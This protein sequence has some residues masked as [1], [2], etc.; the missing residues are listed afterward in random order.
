MYKQSHFHFVGING[1][2]MSGIAKILHKQ[3]HIVS[4]CDLACDTANI[5]EL[6]NSNCKISN[7]HSSNLCNNPSI[8]TVVYSSDVPYNNKELV[9]ARNRG[10]KTVQRAALLAEIMR[11][12]VSI[13]VAGS[14][15]KTTTTAIIGHILMQAQTDPTIIVGGIMHNIANNAHYGT[16]KYVIAETDESDRSHLLLPVTL[17]VLTNVDFEHANVYKNINEVIETFSLFLNKLPFYGKAIICLDDHNIIN[18]LPT[19]TSSTI[20]YGTTKQADIQAINI[21]LH[22]NHSSFDIVDNRTKTIL[23][24]INIEMPSIYNVLNATGAIA[25]ALELE[26]PFTLISQALSSFKGIDRR[27]SYKGTMQTP[28]VEIFDDYG[29]HPT[30]IHHSLITARRTTKNKLVVVFQPQRYTR[31]YHLWN[32]FIT[33]FHTADIDHL[34]ITDI[35]AAN[36][37]IIENITG[38]LLAQAIIAKNPS[39]KVHYVPYQAN[40]EEIQNKVVQ[41][42]SD[43]DLLLFLGAGKVNKLADILL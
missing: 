21:Q 4:G 6:I 9:D 15:G 24:S 39:F 19:L 40:L 18:I 13:G 25:T 32:E 22:A 2:G 31:T 23:G 20:T 35:Y 7:Q 41:I 28:C 30:E 43:N 17:A 38:Q 29:H 3:G 33:T 5:Q 37:P 14:H 27:F 42:I 10:I 8:T 36:E 11:T 34:I 26:I 12:K 1:I 16:G